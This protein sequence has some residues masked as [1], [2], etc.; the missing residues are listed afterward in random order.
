MRDE[1]FFDINILV[2]RVFEGKRK[3]VI[4]NQILAELFC[5]LTRKVKFP[6]SPAEAKVIVSPFLAQRAGRR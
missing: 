2:K 5:V 1:V 6:L 3:G 4:S